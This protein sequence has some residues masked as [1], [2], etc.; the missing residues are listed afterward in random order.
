LFGERR[1]RKMRKVYICT[2]T[3]ILV[4]YGTSI[5]SFA[6]EGEICV[7]LGASGMMR[8]VNNSDQCRPPESRICWNIEGAQGPPGAEGPPGPEGPPGS[9]GGVKVYDATDPNQYLGILVGGGVHGVSEIFMPDLN[10]IVLVNR[11]DGEIP[12]GVW[13]FEKIDC[14]LTG[15]VY[16]G[17]SDLIYRLSYNGDPKYYIGQGPQQWLTVGVDFLSKLRSG[18]FGD[19]CGPDSCC[20]WCENE[21]PGSARFGLYEAYEVLEA[22]PFTVPVALPLRYEYQNE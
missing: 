17:T 8:H 12:V 14:D 4:L 21:S 15:P 6:E 7:C 16:V 20:S 18:C 22:L 2:V 11:S 13:Y 3:I 9:P 19:P 5:K 10:K 1:T